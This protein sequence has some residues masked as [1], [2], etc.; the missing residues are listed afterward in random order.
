[1]DDIIVVTTDDLPGYK[2]VKILGIVSGS[3]VRARHIGR[4][5]MAALRNIAGGEIKEYTELLAQARNDAL[6]RMVEQAKKM[7]ANAIV[8]TRFTTT[9]VASGAAEILVYGTAVIA[10]P[11]Y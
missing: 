6:K 1:M 5:I 9:A 10:E 8:G 11:S 4:D 7:G 3:V 2:I